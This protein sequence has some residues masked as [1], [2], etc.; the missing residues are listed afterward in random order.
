MAFEQLG[1]AEACLEQARDYALQRFAFGQPIGKFQAIKHKVA[2][3]Y[4]ANELARGAALAA[5]L[6]L[7]DGAPDL[8]LKAAAAR[9]NATYAYELAAAEAIQV[10]GAVGVTWEHDLHLHYRRARATALELGPVAA[11]EDRIAQALAEAA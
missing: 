6:A 5:A 10:H 1:G 2:E 3:I 8:P 11:W 4:V 9:I 7:A